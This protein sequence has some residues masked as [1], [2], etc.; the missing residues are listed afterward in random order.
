YRVM[1]YVTVSPVS[2]ISPYSG[3]T[4]IGNWKIGTGR[5]G[6]NGGYRGYLDVTPCDIRAKWYPPSP[7]NGGYQPGPALPIFTRPSQSPHLYWKDVHYAIALP[8]PCLCPSGARPRQHY[9]RALALRPP[10][11]GHEGLREPG[12]PRTPDPQR[13]HLARP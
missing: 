12:Q 13:A 10:G 6:E 2:P 1:T 11:Q 5:I 3:C 4:K 7:E 9:E 8:R